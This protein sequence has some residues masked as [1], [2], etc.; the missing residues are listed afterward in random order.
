[1]EALL[2]FRDHGINLTKLESRPKSDSP[3]EYLF[4]IDIEGHS[5]DPRVKEILFKMA[6]DEKAHLK[7]L[8]DLLGTP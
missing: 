1:M 6:D 5:Q 8:G 3:W 2:V 7:S 4:Y